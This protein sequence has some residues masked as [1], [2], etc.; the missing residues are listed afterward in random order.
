LPV[1]G[2]LRNHWGLYSDEW[3]RL[4]NNRLTASNFERI[5]NMKITTDTANTIKDIL[6]RLEKSKY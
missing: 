5:I 6:C 4:R 2:W 1:I 3:E